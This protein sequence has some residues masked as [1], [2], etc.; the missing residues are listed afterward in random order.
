MRRLRELAILAFGA[1]VLF[2]VCDFVFSWN[3]LA[4]AP[5][6]EHRASPVFRARPLYEL[7]MVAEGINGLVAAAAFLLVRPALPASPR[8]A[9][10]R[11]GLVLWAFWVV[12]GTMSA[13]VWLEV[14]RG[15][16]AM[17]ILFG[18]PKCV[19]IAIGIA[20]IAKLLD[21]ARGKG[22]V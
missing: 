5:Y 18:L 21:D 16:A 4:A 13:M 11:F 19:A 1:S 6:W 15:L 17:N 9:G 22:G 20:W 2:G 3:P 8:R 10:L 14:P 12:S 7:G